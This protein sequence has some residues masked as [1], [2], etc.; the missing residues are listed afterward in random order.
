[1][2]YNCCEMKPR[3]FEKE[4]ENIITTLLY[5]NKPKVRIFQELRRN[6]EKSSFN[7]FNWGRLRDS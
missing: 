6:Y 4:P 7:L 1:M 5:S 3:T 2:R